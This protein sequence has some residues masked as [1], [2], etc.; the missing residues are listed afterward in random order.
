MSK[1]PT[2]PRP[3]PMS[4]GETSGIWTITGDDAGRTF[5]LATIS[6]HLDEHNGRRRH[7]R[8]P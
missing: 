8:V 4:F 2:V 3:W 5:P 7:P 6:C 1:E